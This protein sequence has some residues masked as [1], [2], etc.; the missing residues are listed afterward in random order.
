MMTKTTRGAVVLE[1]GHSVSILMVL[2]L[3]ARKSVFKGPKRSQRK[4]LPILPTAE[5]RLKP[6]TR[7]AP[8]RDDKPS[9]ALYKGRKNGGTK[10]GKVAT[11]P[12]KKRM[13]NRESR[14]SRLYRHY[15]H[16]KYNVRRHDMGIP[17]DECTTSDWCTLFDQ[18][19]GRQACGQGH[20]AQSAIGPSWSDTLDESIGDEADG[21][22][23]QPTSGKYNTIRKT[24]VL[25]KVLRRC[26]TDHHKKETA[27]CQGTSD[28]AGLLK[29]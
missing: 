18:P 21:G 10:S 26:H 9:E 16:A 5:A 6:A 15:S 2:R 25:T 11:A 1:M 3:S 7:L 13:E 20:D 19:G 14:K 4:P 23:T 22:A 8:T 17:F 27:Q 28:V 24:P 12:A 29:R